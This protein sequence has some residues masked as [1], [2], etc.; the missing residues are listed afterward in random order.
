MTETVDQKYADLLRRL[1]ETGEDIETRNSRVRRLF[2]EKIVFDSTPLVGV[3]KTAWRS[4][5]KEWAWFQSGSD[6]INSLDPAVRHWWLPWANSEGQVLFNYSDQFRAACGNDGE[7]VDQIE[8]LVDGIKN[9]PYSRRNVLTTWN[10]ADMASSRC[11]ITNCH[12]TV[13]QTFVDGKGLLHL[14]T[15]QRSV[16]VVCGLPHNWI[17]EAA[18]H[19]WLCSQTKMSMGSLTWIGG[20]VHLYEQHFE[21]ARECVDRVGECRPTPLLCY[22]PT[23]DYFQAEDF[24]LDGEYL[25]VIDKRAE[26]V[27]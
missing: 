21:L 4:A 20:D 12:N 17:Q 14:V 19:L 18:F 26:M 16:D 15:Y 1:L 13:T 2:A 27:V 9:H 5:I 23:A 25:P 3:R 7:V 22:Q 10:A 24:Y 6:D 11:P 8:L